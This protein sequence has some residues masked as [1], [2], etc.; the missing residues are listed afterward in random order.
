MI[1]SI[2]TSSAADLAARLVAASGDAIIVA[3]AAGRIVLWNSGAEATFGYSV[4][5]AVGQTLDIIIPERLRARHWE[6]YQRTMMTGVTRYA[7]ELLAVPGQRRDGTRVSLEFRV[8]LLPGPDGRPE[9]I[10]AILRD[11]TERWEADRAL[12]TELA[13]L[14]ALAEMSNSERQAQ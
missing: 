2:N 9:A 13:Q 8:A 4:A 11:V 5:E 12:R 14:R 6:G 7:K 10:A 1:N 3:D